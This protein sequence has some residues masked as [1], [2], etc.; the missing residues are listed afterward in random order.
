MSIFDLG[1]WMQGLHVDTDR[2]WH[3]SGRFQQYL[4]SIE[5]PKLRKKLSVCSQCFG[6]CTAT[7][8]CKKMRACSLSSMSSWLKS[9]DFLVVRYYL[10]YDNTKTRNKLREGWDVI[11][12]MQTLKPLAPFN[13]LWMCLS[14]NG[15][16][17]ACS[18]GITCQNF[19]RY[20]PLWPGTGIMNYAI[21]S[22]TSNIASA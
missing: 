13:P 5:M 7:Q 19:H 22:L 12:Q 3:G 21:L 11:I 15:F 20:H 8:N 1:N 2:L 6:P 16:A 10:Q 14:V 4:A 17:I 9:L 18:M